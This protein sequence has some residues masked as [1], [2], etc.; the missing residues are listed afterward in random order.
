MVGCGTLLPTLVIVA[1]WLNWPGSGRAR[2]RDVSETI[3]KE[4]H[5]GRARAALWRGTVPVLVTATLCFGVVACGDGDDPATAPAADNRR[6]TESTAK[7]T[8]DE[9]NSGESLTSE[10]I[11]RAV[12]PELVADA[13][14]LI[15]TGTEPSDGST[16]QC[17]YTYPSP[18]GPDSNLTVAASRY[19]E[20]GAPSI[21]AAY[22]SAVAINLSTAGADAT[23]TSIDSGD[24]AVFIS[25]S[26]L[27]LGV[28]RVGDVLVTS[29]VP[30]DT[31]D[32]ERYEALLVA[33]GEA[34]A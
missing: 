12:P 9:E 6:S 19:T 15:I 2:E 7:G 29:I 5:S 1:S 13:T 22:E 4:T 21:D 28:L 34:F 16:P 23:Q 14:G 3:E 26:V 30:P 20:D 10:D 27:A 31:I 18:N 17:A 24:E 32:A 25:G 8:A 11:C 33:L